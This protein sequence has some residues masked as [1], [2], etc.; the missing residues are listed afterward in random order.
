MGFF[1]Y[2]IHPEPQ[3]D[4][5]T[6]FMF[7]FVTEGLRLEQELPDELYL[8]TRSLSFVGT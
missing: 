4:D 7:G 8:N 2:E 1:Y 3:V 6:V 5:G